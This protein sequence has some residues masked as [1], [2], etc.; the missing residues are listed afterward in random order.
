MEGLQS[1]SGGLDSAGHAGAGLGSGG[2]AVWQ[3]WAAFR[4]KC[5]RRLGEVEELQSGSGR[6]DSAR[7]WA[8]GSGVVEA[9][10]GLGIMLW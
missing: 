4:G 1:G 2:A 8:A 6:L 7:N 9:N 3:W 5:G 10:V